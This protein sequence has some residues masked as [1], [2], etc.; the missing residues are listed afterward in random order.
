MARRT[1]E[2]LRNLVKSVRDRSFPYEK[3]ES[4]KRN[5]SS[6]DD[7]QV[8]EIADVLE[9]IRDI[10]DMAASN[11]PEKKKTAGR[12]PVPASDVVKVML[13]QAYFGMPNRIAEGFLR[14]FGEKLGISSSFSYKTIERGYDPDRTKE[15]L[16]EVHRIMNLSGNPEE[17]IFST[18][19]TG[20]PATMKVNYESRR[21]LQ[22]QEKEKHKTDDKEK[23]DAFP[24]TK[25]KHDFQYSVFSAGVHTK[26]IAGFATTDNHSI[27][28]LSHFPSIMSQT[29]DL[30]PGIEE[31]LGDALYS[32]RKMCSIT[33]SYG[34]DQYFLPKTNASFR[35]KGVASWK[36]MLYDFADNTQSW[37]EHY[38]MRSISECVNSMMKRK[39][40]VKIRK[41]LPQ[42]KKTEETLKINMHNLRQY[43]YLKHTKPDLIE[44]YRDISAK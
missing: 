12:P 39:M 42:R 2:D 14:L 35:A 17:N 32:N 18:D 28:E 44:D 25:G 7:A 33:Q 31:M 13:M 27:G 30:A 41:K 36:A 37:L 26:M 4:K 43:N 40:P 21:S 9:T 19:G 6:Y 3:R 24:S 38:H 1:V 23:S 34:I 5:W 10:V 20:D 11:L 29:M 22:R 15:L 8:N 16:D